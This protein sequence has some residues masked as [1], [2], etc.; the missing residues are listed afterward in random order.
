VGK[1][2]PDVGGNGNR[3]GNKDTFK[4]SLLRFLNNRGWITS[5]TFGYFRWRI[6]KDNS[7]VQS[8]LKE[9]RVVFG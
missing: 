1:P 3:N 5:Q 8:Q 6:S 2:I 9:K 7:Y 4:L